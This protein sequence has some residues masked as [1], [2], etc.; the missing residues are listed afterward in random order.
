MG[1]CAS[2]E[3][4]LSF[5]SSPSTHYKRQDPNSSSGNYMNMFGVWLIIF[6][7]LIFILLIAITWSLQTIVSDLDKKLTQPI[8]ERLDALEFRFAN[9]D[10][11]TQ[12]TSQRVQN[13]SDM[14]SQTLPSSE[15]VKQ[16]FEKI[17]EADLKR[18]EECI[19]G[20]KCHKKEYVVCDSPDIFTT[21]K[22]RRSSKSKKHKDHRRRY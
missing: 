21:S 15:K 9:I 8:S 6:M 5:S 13:L 7:I 22:K 20:K 16:S 1:S 2:S 11:S 17:A 3:E 19:C 10:T 12:G 4:S 14:L 18:I